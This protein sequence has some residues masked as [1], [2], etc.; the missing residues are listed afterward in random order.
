MAAARAVTVAGR[1]DDLGD[2]VAGGRGEREIR[3]L[4]SPQEAAVVAVRTATAVR[5]MSRRGRVVLA[6][7]GN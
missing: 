7:R 6:G 1:V 4:S 5:A 2:R 3:R